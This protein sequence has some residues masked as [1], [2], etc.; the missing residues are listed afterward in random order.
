MTNRNYTHTICQFQLRPD[1]DQWSAII[2]AGNPS[3]EVVREFFVR[4]GIAENTDLI[5]G[6]QAFWKM[7]DLMA[8]L[9][10]A[11]FSHSSDELPQLVRKVES[12]DV[13]A[14]S[15]NQN[16]TNIQLGERR[17]EQ[18]QQTFAQHGY[19]IT[20]QQVEDLAKCSILNASRQVLDLWQAWKMPMKG[21]CPS[22][23]FE[24]EILIEAVIAKR[25]KSI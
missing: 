13:L 17:A 12:S 20:D 25:R 7:S 5:C 18:V 11:D 23:P 21:T 8:Y 22:M 15:D 6:N 9:E 19:L 14:S 3:K 4:D 2:I 10:V 16:E 1:L 24:S